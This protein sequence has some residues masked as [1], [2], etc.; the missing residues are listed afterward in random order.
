MSIPDNI[1]E[2]FCRYKFQSIDQ[3][4]LLWNPFSLKLYEQFYT[5][6]TNEML[7]K[8]D[9]L[10]KYMM[11]CALYPFHKLDSLDNMDKNIMCYNIHR[12]LLLKIF[13]DKVL[14]QDMLDQHIV[15]MKHCCDNIFLPKYPDIRVR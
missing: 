6:V 8:F 10:A 3:Y 11:V 13:S 14:D 12:N 9:V 1:K 4:K 7:C 2:L 5:C 15:V